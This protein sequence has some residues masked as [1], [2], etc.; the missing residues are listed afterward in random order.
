VTTLPDNSLP[1]PVLMYVLIAFALLFGGT[2]MLVCGGLC[3]LYC[4]RKT[5]RKYGSRA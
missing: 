2:T 5:G 4:K 1:Q 3:G